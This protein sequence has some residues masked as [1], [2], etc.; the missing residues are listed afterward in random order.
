[1]LALAMITSILSGP[2]YWRSC[3]LLPVTVSSSTNPQLNWCKYSMRQECLKCDVLSQSYADVP[4]RKFYELLSCLRRVLQPGSNDGSDV[5]VEED[6]AIHGLIASSAY[7]LKCSFWNITGNEMI[8]LERCDN[9]SRVHGFVR[10]RRSLRPQCHPM[11][12]QASA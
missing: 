5:K 1:M 8:H 9:I 12:L 7:I 10:I 3:C 11:E 4:S 6:R 2:A